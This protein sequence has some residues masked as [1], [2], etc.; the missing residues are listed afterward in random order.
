MNESIP[1]TSK[2]L[3]E[4][5]ELSEIVLK[6]IELAQLPLANIAL[7]VSRLAR[8]LNDFDFQKIMQYE[9]GGIPCPPSGISTD[10]WKLALMAERTYQIKDSKTTEIK[11]Y[12]HIKSI[13]QLEVEI[14]SANRGIVAASDRDVSVSS[15]NPS[16]FV[17]VPPPNSFERNSH[18]ITVST[19]TK[20]LSE[21]RSFIYH[22]V[23]RKHYEL[24]YSG[25]AED[26]FSRIRERVDSTIGKLVPQSIQKFNAIHDNLQTEN[27]ENW[28]NAVHSCR[29]ILEDL[30]DVLLPPQTEDRVKDIN[31]KQTNIKLGQGNY[32]N[33]LLCFVD[34]HSTANRFTEIVGSNFSYLSDRLDSVFQA[35]QKG[36][37]DEIVSRAEA[38]RYVVYT[39]MVVAD[40]LS[41]CE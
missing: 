21:R 40:I 34:D 19:N 8:L 17:H 10:D 37:H 7:K 12:A 5:L 38:D 23:L 24:K 11:T 18:Q 1:A 27:P 4:A 16:Q 9:V 25:I 33:R 2:A 31:G 41:L 36:T 22:Y 14:E 39:Y 28:A 32:K 13:E 30:A 3:Y 35:S 15:A 29:R 20:L 6:D 26:L